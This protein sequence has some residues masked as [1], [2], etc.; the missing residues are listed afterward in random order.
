MLRVSGWYV[1]PPLHKIERHDLQW[2]GSVLPL[3]ILSCT[4]HGPALFSGPSYISHTAQFMLDAELLFRLL[5]YI[6]K[7]PSPEGCCGAL[8]SSPAYISQKGLLQS[9]AVAL[10]STPYIYTKFGP[11]FLS[12]TKRSCPCCERLVS[13]HNY[14]ALRKI[15]FIYILET[16][17]PNALSLSKWST[18]PLQNNFLDS[19]CPRSS[20]QLFH[21]C[22]QTHC[23][24]PQ[25]VFSTGTHGWRGLRKWSR[26]NIHLFSEARLKRADQLRDVVSQNSLHPK[27]V[28]QMQT[29][30]STCRL[31]F[32]PTRE[33]ISVQNSQI[34]GVQFSPFF[35]IKINSPHT[36]VLS[37]WI[38]TSKIARKD[39][40]PTHMSQNTNQPLDVPPAV[41]W[42][43]YTYMFKTLKYIHASSCASKEHSSS[44][45]CGF[46][47]FWICLHIYI[48]KTL[49]SS[50]PQRSSKGYHLL[51]WLKSE[52]DSIMS[53]CGLVLAQKSTNITMM[54]LLL[55]E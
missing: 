43:K 47:C 23:S 49:K 48:S 2:L 53:V 51:L 38:S 13:L 34:V 7:H 50:Q 55:K 35:T 6:S 44:S 42:N 3:K 4:R 32:S 36:H 45:M 5:I 1:Y 27:H 19:W 31:L 16:I 30:R 33:Y 10:F 54:S 17:C 29:S 8:F 26:Q 12:K 24:N 9:H 14:P 52:D 20:R 11:L 40:M 41:S 46:S 28:S 18:L 21:S 22:A 15:L 39:F 25:Q 37:P